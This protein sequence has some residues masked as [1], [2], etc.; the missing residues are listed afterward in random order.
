MPPSVDL[1][2]RAADLVTSDRRHLIGL[3]TGAVVA[4]LVIALL[5]VG[6]ALR[7]GSTVIDDTLTAGERPPAPSLTLPVLVSVPGFPPAGQDMALS[8]LT[9]RVV[10][11]NLWASWCG[12]CRDEAPILESTWNAFR[13]RSV[14]VLGINIQDLSDDARGFITEFTITY[15]SLRDG[16]DRTMAVLEATGVPETYLLDRAGH[17]ALHIAGPIGS[18]DQLA[19]PIEQLLAEK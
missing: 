10:V 13:D 16:S 3:I 1:D 7:G 8:D 9:G 18:T 17:I 5:V 4:A 6:L 11:L 19:A 12:P 14:V 15:P 2:P